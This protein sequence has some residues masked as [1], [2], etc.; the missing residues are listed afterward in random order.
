MSRAA[1]C[2][3]SAFMESCIGTVKAELEMTEYEY[4]RAAR[5]EIP[6]YIAYY[7]NDRIHSAFDYMTPNSFEEKHRGEGRR[8]RP[9]K[10][11]SGASQKSAHL[12]QA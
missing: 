11:A 9:P 3:D 2:Y 7:N 10:Y 6:E 1:N 8:R 12:R 4:S 5:R